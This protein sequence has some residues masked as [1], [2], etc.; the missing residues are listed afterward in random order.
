[1]GSQETIRRAAQST[2]GKKQ[3]EAALNTQAATQA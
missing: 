3:L 1:M 2:G